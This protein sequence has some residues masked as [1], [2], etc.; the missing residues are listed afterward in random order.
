MKTQII[1]Q[2]WREKLDD[3]RGDLLRTTDRWLQRLK[4]EEREEAARE[5][6]KDFWQPSFGR[7]FDLPDLPKVNV[8]EN[9]DT[10][11]V[12]AELPGL[13]KEDLHVDLDGRRLTIHGETRENREEKRGRSHVSELRF[14]SFTRV[15]PLP[16]EVER[17]K[18]KAKYRHG[19]LKLTLPKTEAAKLRRIPVHYEE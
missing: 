1:P 17:E 8:E 13:K 14:G 19:I 16:C 18:T 2:S 10:I 5:M 6:A 3:L 4:P 9:D 15:I 7:L 12:V 11:E